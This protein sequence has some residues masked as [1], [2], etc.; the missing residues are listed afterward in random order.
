MGE[1]EAVRVRGYAMDN[2]EH[3]KNIRC[4]AVPF[5]SETG[6]IE[7]AL[8]AAGTIIDIPDE[9]S[10]QKTVDRLKDARDRIRLEMGYSDVSTPATGR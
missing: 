6:R 1:L 10:I 2:A 5:F 7:A 8:S 3:E 9:E 4:L